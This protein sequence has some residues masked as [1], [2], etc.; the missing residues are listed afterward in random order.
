VV[1]PST[2]GYKGPGREDV[3]VQTPSIDVGEIIFREGG[4]INVA[5]TSRHGGAIE[6]D[7][8]CGLLSDCLQDVRFTILAMLCLFAYD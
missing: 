6:H 5:L 7:D 1:P 3:Q 4:M 2:G 8:L